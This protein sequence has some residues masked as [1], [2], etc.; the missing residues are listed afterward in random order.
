M[1]AI[2]TID[3]NGKKKKRKEKRRQDNLQTLGM[4]ETTTVVKRFSWSGVVLSR[5]FSWNF[6][7]PALSIYQYVNETVSLGDTAISLHTFQQQPGGGGVF[8]GSQNSKCQELPKFQFLEGG[9]WWWWWWLFLGSQIVNW[10]SWQNEQKFCH[11][12]SWKP[13]HRR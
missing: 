12:T 6:K 13:L 10:Y 8:L 9:G 5:F 11:A 4:N 2:M 7:L 1:T 3:G